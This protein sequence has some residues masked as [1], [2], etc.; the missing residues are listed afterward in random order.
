MFKSTRS[1]LSKKNIY[2]EIDHGI[3]EFVLTP[4]NDGSVLLHALIYILNDN[5]YGVV[6]DIGKSKTLKIYV[7]EDNN[8][9]IGQ[10]EFYF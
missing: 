1:E 7:Y 5:A 6:K 2:F 10:G 8:R 3:E 9:I 4:T